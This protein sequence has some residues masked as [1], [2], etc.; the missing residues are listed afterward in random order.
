MT[1]DLFS[2]RMRAN[3]GDAHVS[4][5]ETIARRGDVDAVAS[6][7]VARALDH[8]RGR[9]NDV[10]VTVDRLDEAPRRVRAL[11]V[12]TVDAAGVATC[13]RVARRL[14]E[15]AGVAPSVVDEGIDCL[16]SETAERGAALLD[17]RDGTRHDPAPERGVRVSRLGCSDAGGAALDDAL[18]ANGLASTRI[19]D[20][21]L[22]ATKVARAPGTVAEL[23]WSDNPD[24]TAGYVATER[25]YYRFPD[26]KPAGDSRGGRVFFL[27]PDADVEAT[28]DFLERRPVL[29][30]DVG[31]FE[32]VAPD[33]VPSG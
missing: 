32:T 8:P 23:C 27:S 18:D 6:E 9:P 25:G 21:L 29:V 4:G 24:Y 10:V 3:E 20:A 17:A 31:T 1:D 5:A 11:P 22:L 13:R 26:L 30:D 33:A 15:R 19:R 12:V 7:M 14:L 2:V 16:E 28:V